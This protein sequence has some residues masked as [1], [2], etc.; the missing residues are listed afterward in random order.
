M[1]PTF[2]AG[3]PL[4]GSVFD[5]PDFFQRVMRTRI[6]LLDGRTAHHPHAACRKLLNQAVLDE[7]EFEGRQLSGAQQIVSGNESGPKGQVMGANHIRGRSVHESWR[8]PFALRF[9]A[10][11]RMRTRSRCSG[12]RQGVFGSTSHL[13]W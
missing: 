6:A 2:L 10:C 11:L 1:R 9:V 8:E 7:Q 13:A 4:P 12:E 5:L 3:Q